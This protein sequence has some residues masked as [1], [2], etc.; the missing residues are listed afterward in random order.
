M[1]RFG[2]SAQQKMKDRWGGSFILATILALVGA[3]YAGDW[4]N[5]ALTDGG[6]TAEDP[7]GFFGSTD[8]AGTGGSGAT[9]ASATPMD[10]KLHFVQVGAFSTDANAQ[11]LVKRLTTKN[12]NAFVG[13]K[14]GNLYPVLVGPF[15]SAA[16]ATEAETQL[17]ADKVMQKGMARSV[18]V[19]HN[20]GSVA[21]MT[22][23]NADDLQKG[24]DALNSYL[25]EAAAWME[26]HAVNPAADARTVV[27]RGK[28][29]SM[30]VTSM[31]DDV[32]DPAVKNFVD[33][34]TAASANAGQIEIAAQ[35]TATGTEYQD[36]VKGY[37]SLLDKYQVLQAAKK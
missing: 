18:T 23:T 2:R 28:E 22:G 5:K 1:H 15:T 8:S 25:Q 35:A 9:L 31:S 10:F 11:S 6:D 16:A 36:V 14:S 34:A 19:S 32:N 21:V 29:L 17:V 12:Y 30:L 7:G 20:A 3:W 26:Q 24:M 33:L 27:S 13:S 37:M 4:L